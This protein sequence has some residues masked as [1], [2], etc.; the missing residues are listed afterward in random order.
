MSA[1]KSYA[2]PVKVG[3]VMIGGTVSQVV[4]SNLD[5]FAVGDWVAAFGGWQDYAVSDGRG[6]VNLGK[7]PEYPTW[8]LGVLGM[9]GLTAY[10]G[11]T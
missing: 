5:R 6:V 3:E 1:A 4:N 10:A 2:D 11:L 8:A 7:S 9:P